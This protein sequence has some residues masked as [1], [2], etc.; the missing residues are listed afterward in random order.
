[1]GQLTTLAECDLAGTGSKFKLFLNLYNLGGDRS[2]V[3]LAHHRGDAIERDHLCSYYME[4]VVI[5]ARRP[6]QRRASMGTVATS[7]WVNWALK[8]SPGT[9]YH[10]A[11]ISRKNCSTK[12]NSDYKLQLKCWQP[13]NIISANDTMVIYQHFKCITIDTVIHIVKVKRQFPYPQLSYQSNEIVHSR[14]RGHP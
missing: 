13:C 14:R 3:G 7:S 1:M 6:T 2:V 8:D 9:T 5:H 10:A 4:R 12:K 11:C